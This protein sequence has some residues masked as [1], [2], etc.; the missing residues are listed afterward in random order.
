MIHYV[1]P[2]FSSLFRL[3]AY[4]FLRVIPSRLGIPVLPTL[5]LLHLAAASLFP[6]PNDGPHPNWHEKN[7]KPPPKKQGPS[8]L[9][10]LFFSLPSPSRLLTWAT[11]SINTVLLLAAADLVVTPYLDPASDVVFT[12]VGAV[13]PDSVKILVRYPTDEPLVV[14]YRG[15]NS[16][17]WIRGPQLHPSEQ[18]DWAETVWLQDL[19]PSTLYEYTLAYSNSTLLPYP[20]RPIQFRTFPDPR[21]HS[22][23]HFRFLATSCITPNFP[24][25]GPFHRRTITGFELLANYLRSPPQEP[26]LLNDTQPATQNITAPQPPAEFLLFLGDFIYADVPTYIGDNQEAY[27]R[28]YRRN[29]QSPSFRKVYEQLPIFHAYDDH[30]FIN[31]YVGNSEDAAPFQSA[32][33]AYN[34]YAGNVNY[35]SPR[36]AQNFYDFRRGDVAFFVMDTR[37]YRSAPSTEPDTYR[38]MLGD[39]QL[40]ALYNWLHKVNETCSFKFIVS[41]VPFTSLWTHDAQIDSWAAFPEEKAALLKAF[42]SVPNVVIISGDRHEFAAIEFASPDPALHTVR[43]ISTSPLS[44]FYIPFIHTL[45][46]Q[47]EAFFIRNVTDAENATATQVPLEKV[48]S[49]IPHGNS[50][51]SSFEIDTRDINKP[52]LRLETVIDG[53]PVYHLEI[54]GAPTRPPNFTGL[55]SLVA[56][57]VLDLFDKIGLKPAK[58]F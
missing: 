57:N 27:R 3:A 11:V 8:P 25:K 48:I 39:V 14:L 52:M 26:L 29:Y 41:S 22:S 35:D 47:S 30:E 40:T 20:E 17:S 42:H 53:K 37:R 5:Y 46:P 34:I 19:W 28:L 31:N 4:L 50:K 12:R 54:T 15:S 49:Y 18:S 38:T 44:M 32:S 58:W 16:V 36:L 10:V 1:A 2:V 55:G 24:Y 6:P 51:W 7:H 33:D 56:T 23:S 9:S 13:H 45:Q 43:E 21:F